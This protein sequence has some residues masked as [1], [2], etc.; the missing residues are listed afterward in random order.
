MATSIDLNPTTCYVVVLVYFATA[1]R[2]GK[3]K[4]VYDSWEAA[5]AHLYGLMRRSE[6]KPCEVWAHAEGGGLAQ[7]FRT[8]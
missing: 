5:S 4:R 2:R 8:H 6:S 3:Y 1:E 7:S